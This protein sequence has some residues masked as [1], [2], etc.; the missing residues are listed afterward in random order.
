M[1]ELRPIMKDSV[2]TFHALFKPDSDQKSPPS[3]Q[4]YLSISPVYDSLYNATVVARNSDSPT[5]EAGRL[6]GFWNRATQSSLDELRRVVTEELSTLNGGARP[7]V[8]DER[9]I[10]R[11]S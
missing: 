10:E 4:V 9:W 8:S 2:L 3:Y 11:E 1:P 7:M 5:P 6:Q